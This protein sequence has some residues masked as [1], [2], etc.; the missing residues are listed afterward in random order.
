MRSFLSKYDRITCSSDIV[1][2]GDFNIDLLKLNDKEIFSEFFDLFTSY[3]FFPKITLPTRFLNNNCTLKDNFFC[4]VS[5]NTLNSSS[6]IMLKQ[7]SDHQPYFL[8][9]NIKQH[10]SSNPKFVKVCTQSEESLKNFYYDIQKCDI[11]K[12][13]NHNPY[14]NPNINYE[15]MSNLINIS[16]EAYIPTKNG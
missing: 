15:I 7:F 4:K 6:G 8:C 5:T 11:M 2:A 13:I 1:L 10:I 9:L 3:S 14:A 12:A 16:R